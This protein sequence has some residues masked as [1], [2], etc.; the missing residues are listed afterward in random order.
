MKKNVLILLLLGLV[1]LAAACGGADSSSGAIDGDEIPV[2]EEG[3]GEDADGQT[4]LEKAQEDGFI[5]VGFANERPYAY[6]TSSG[7]LT[8]LN[9]E[10]AKAVFAKLGIE[11]VDGT[12]AQFGALIPGLQAGRYD[13]ITAGMYITPERCAEV[14]FAE[15]EYSIGEGLAVAQGNPLNLNS[16]EDIIENSDATVAIMT[17]AIEETYLNNMGIGSGQIQNVNDNPSAI[18]ALKAG[19]VDA[20]TMTGP[21]L[22]DALD[23]HGDESIEIVEDFIQPE[24]DG[25]SVR[26]FG[27]AAFRQ[28]DQDFVEAYNEGLAELMESGEL[29]EIYEEFGF[30][31][32]ELPGDMTAQQACGQ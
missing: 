18:E 7:E 19:R 27:S 17:G 32:E 10:I 9:V 20:I 22:R 4:T 13:V 2:F 24:I 5:K 16:Y 12:L 21:S 23:I 8:G 11:E 31:D 26:G 29:L 28:A 14:A 30:T 15:P 25:E 6:A 1:M 3:N